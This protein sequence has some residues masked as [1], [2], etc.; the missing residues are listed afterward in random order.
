SSL[1]SY[2]NTRLTEVDLLQS[3]QAL[4]KGC[5][6]LIGKDPITYLPATCLECCCLIC[7]HM[8]WLPGRYKDCPYGTGHTSQNHLP[9]CPLIPCPLLDALP[10]PPTDNNPINFTISSLPTSPHYSC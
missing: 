2:H 10:S 9:K 1:R 3:T 4:M 6:R 8:G 5:C 7:W